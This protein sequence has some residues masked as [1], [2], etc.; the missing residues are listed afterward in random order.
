MLP[1]ARSVEA[2]KPEPPP[3]AVATPVPQPAAADF[4]LVQLGTMR[5][6]QFLVDRRSGRVWRSVCLT[7]GAAMTGGVTRGPDCNGLEMWEEMYVD[8]VTPP[9]SAAAWEYTAYLQRVAS[10]AQ[11]HDPGTG[12][13]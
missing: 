10:D 7:S 6:D 9:E 1:D 13:R 4:H 3:V 12:H 2:Q 8:G 5:R 11:P